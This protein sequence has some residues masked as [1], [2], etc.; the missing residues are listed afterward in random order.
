MVIDFAQ[1]RRLCG[2]TVTFM[3]Y[4]RA[5]PVADADFD[6]ERRPDLPRGIDL[7]G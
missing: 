1:Y 3:E 7:A 5:D 6:V 4:L 2:V